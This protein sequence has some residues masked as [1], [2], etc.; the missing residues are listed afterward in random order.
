MTMIKKPLPFDEWV[1]KSGMPIAEMAACFWVYDNLQIARRMFD[2]LGVRP[3][4]SALV[5]VAKMIALR[6]EHERE[7]LRVPQEDE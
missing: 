5:E 2:D 7:S 3:S 1:E 6:I 4:A